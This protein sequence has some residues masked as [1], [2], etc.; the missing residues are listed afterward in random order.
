MPAPTRGR[1]AKPANFAEF[2]SNAEHSLIELP[3]W[4]TTLALAI[5][6]ISDPEAA[7]ASRVAG[8]AAKA[9]DLLKN[10]LIPLFRDIQSTIVNANNPMGFAEPFTFAGGSAGETQSITV[11]GQPWVVA[12]TSRIV[13]INNTQPA[14]SAIEYYSPAV[15]NLVTGVGFDVTLTTTDAATPIGQTGSVLWIG[16]PN[17]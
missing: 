12:G 11:T 16:F 3:K 15:T 8:G 13:P 14:T 6:A 9:A 17:G 10:D 7:K 2:L 5:R 4:L 1:I